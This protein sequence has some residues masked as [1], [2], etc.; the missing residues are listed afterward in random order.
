MEGASGWQPSVVPDEAPT[1]LWT[2]VFAAVALWWL[3]PWLERLAPQPV[4][5]QTGKPLTKQQRLEAQAEAGLPVGEPQQSPEKLP[6]AIQKEPPSMPELKVFDIFEEAFSQSVEIVRELLRTPPQGVEYQIAIGACH[7]MTNILD[8][9]FK[10]WGNPEELARV[11]CLHEGSDTFRRN[12]GGHR[13]G[14]HSRAMLSLA[15]FERQESVSESA[16]KSSATWVFLAQEPQARIR[17]L[18]VRLCLQSVSDLQRLRGTLRWV[19]DSNEAVVPR[20]EDV[21]PLQLLKLY[22]SL[23]YPDAGLTAPSL[24]ERNVEVAVRMRIMDRRK[25]KLGEPAVALVVHTGLAGA[26]RAM[27]QAQRSF[28]RESKTGEIKA[29]VSTEVAE[30]L[31]RLPLPPGFEAAHLH[32]VS[33]ELPSIFGLA[34]TTGGSSGGGDGDRA[35]EILAN[36]SV[37]F[38]AARQVE[39]LAWPC[40][41]LCGIGASLDYTVNRG[42]IVALLVGFEGMVPSAEF[43][44]TTEK[45]EKKASSATAPAQVSGGRTFGAKVHTL[46]SNSEAS[47]KPK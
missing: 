22:K 37:G 20:R 26:A 27:A 41:A 7:S 11:S 1:L 10:D 24:R 4:P 17:A 19:Q 5:A 45:L 44:S 14:Q 36:E 3:W 15:G 39:D 47:L 13:V 30:H 25:E 28:T 31:A 21:C 43:A 38:W 34:S 8:R 9:L 42:F 40:A 32:F 18:T 23:P 2:L 6:D 35:A 46:D 33:D 16:S 12:F 29:L